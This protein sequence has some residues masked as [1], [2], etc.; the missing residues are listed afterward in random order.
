MFKKIFFVA[1]LAITAIGASAQA[2]IG[3]KGGL[4]FANAKFVAGT[5]TETLNSIVTPNFGLTVDF[6]GSNS[7]NIQSGLSFNGMGG[8]LTEGTNTWKTNLNYLSIPVLAKFAIGSGFSGYAGPQL[9]FLLSAKDK[10]AGGTDD[11]KDE[12]KGSSI[13]GIFGLNYSLNDKVS[14]FG[15]YNAGISNLSKST[16]NGEKTSANAFSI[17]VAVGLK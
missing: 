9:S 7:F 2:K 11:I 8:K 10:Y 5:S 1:V 17:G 4:S 12:V 15:E 6:P 13:F 14:F 3:L 16:T